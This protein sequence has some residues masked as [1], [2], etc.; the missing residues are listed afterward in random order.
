MRKNEIKR[1]RGEKREIKNKRER[2]RKKETEGDRGRERERVRESERE[3]LNC[4]ELCDLNRVR[5]E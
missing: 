3:R 2:E 5:V 1:Y 4:I